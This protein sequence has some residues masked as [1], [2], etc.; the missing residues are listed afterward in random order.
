MLAAL[1][2]KRIFWLASGLYLLAALYF[3]YDKVYWFYFTPVVLL[4]ALA[5]L[6]RMDAIFFLTVLIVPLSINFDET[7]LG[8]GINVPTEPVT[9]GLMLLMLFKILMEGGIDKKILRHPV[10]ILILLHL[11]WMIVTTLTS[12]LLLVSF[13]YTLARISFVTVFYFYG[14]QLFAKASNI[15]RFA[16]LYIVSL[17]IVI[18]YTTYNH[19]VNFFT[20]EAAHSAMTPFYY[21]HTQYAAM[22][23]MFLPLVLSI[24]FTSDFTKAQ[25][26]GAFITFL[27]LATGLVLSYTRAAWIGVAAALLCS[28][29]FILR[30]HTSLVWAAIVVFAIFLAFNISSIIL[31]LE[32]TKEASS[33]DLASHLQSITNIKTDA[34][35]TER[36]NRWSSAIRMFKQKPLTGYGPGTYQFVY[37]PFQ[38]NRELTYISTSQGNRGNAHSEYLGPLAEQG[39]PGSL[40]FIAI[41]IATLITASDFIINCQ[42]RK[43]RAIAIGLILG[44]ITYWVHGFLN[45]FLHTEKASIPYWGF[46]GAIAAL[47]IYHRNTKEKHVEKV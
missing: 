12:D 6:L 40:L 13:K 1:S 37:G 32:T 26:W 36:I 47:D 23:A 38:L 30:I 19:A 21:D 8:F 15:S 20:E 39:L 4:V 45:N 10:T 31:N 25:R 41:G 16:W 28:F 5:A 29:I 9:F 44:M 46:I 2:D 24:L 34:S 18:V 7:P 42:S 27:F 14:I 3:T 22:I 17:I 43:L 35:N 33:D 11:V